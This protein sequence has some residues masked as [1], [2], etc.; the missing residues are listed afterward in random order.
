L[1]VSSVRTGSSPPAFSFPPE[2]LAF[3]WHGETFDLPAG[4]VHLAR[5][6]ACENQAF[7]LGGRVIGLQFH[8]ETT[9]QTASEIVS[10]CRKELAPSRYVQTEARILGVRAEAYDRINSVMKDVLD[11]VTATGSKPLSRKKP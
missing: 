1:P 11:F 3:H 2:I 4:A 6:A 10:N 7:Q 9:P 5:S 8:L